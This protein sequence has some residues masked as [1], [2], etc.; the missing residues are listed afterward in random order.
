MSEW[1]SIDTAPKDGTVVKVVS[2]TKRGIFTYYPYPITSAFHN[3]KWC[4]KL[5]KEDW[6]S[7]DPQPTHWMPLPAP[8]PP[9]GK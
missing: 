2:A 1:Q 6:T 5:D 7:F 3:G 8:P 4:W 9:L